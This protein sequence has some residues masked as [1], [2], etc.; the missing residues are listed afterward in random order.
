MPRPVITVGYAPQSSAVRIQRNGGFG[1]IWTQGI[2]RGMI[3]G[4][5]LNTIIARNQ[6]GGINVGDRS[7]TCGAHS[8]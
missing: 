6:S 8:A 3:D 4:A 7:D 2:N 1:F 5:M